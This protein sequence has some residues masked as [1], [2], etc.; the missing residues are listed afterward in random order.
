MPQAPNQYRHC[1]AWRT[2]QRLPCSNLSLQI[3][4]LRMCSYQPAP[5]TFLL[6]HNTY[7]RI[8]SKAS[9]RSLAR[10]TS[11]GQCSGR[12]K[13]ISASEFSCTLWFRSLIVPPGSSLSRLHS[14]PML[15]GSR[16]SRS[17][18]RTLH[19]LRTTNFAPKIWTVAQI[20]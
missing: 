7:L 20:S 13:R 6:C 18:A 11:S 16:F 14:K 4:C 19:T 3:S 8:S 2:L 9:R 17:S 5:P 15:Y 12:L 1:R 10:K